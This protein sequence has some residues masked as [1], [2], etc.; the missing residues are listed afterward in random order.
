MFSKSALGRRRK[1]TAPEGYFPADA[2]RTTAFDPDHQQSPKSEKKA[3]SSSLKNF[4]FTQSP[5][6]LD[7][8]PRPVLE[9]LVFQISEDIKA[10]GE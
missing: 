7:V 4:F 8:I 9:E 10:R 6:H 1:T 2:E 3:T 5:Y